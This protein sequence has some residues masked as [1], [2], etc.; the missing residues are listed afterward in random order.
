[1]EGKIDGKFELDAISLNVRGLNDTKKR[2]SI[3]R[4]LH[5]SRANLICLQET[6]STNECHSVWINQWGGNIIFSDGSNHGK[7]V[8]ILIPPKVDA[9]IIDVSRDDEGRFLYAE[10]A[11]QGTK[12]KIINI[13]GPNDENSSEQFYIGLKNKSERLKIAP[14]DYIIWGG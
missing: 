8:A 9:E 6:Y 2:K 4:W 10:I 5:K 13:Y 14:E 3:F 1:M 7:G 12:F 11:L